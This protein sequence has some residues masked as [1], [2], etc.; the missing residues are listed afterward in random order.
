MVVESED[1]EP[2][3]P[4]GEGVGGLTKCIKFFFFYMLTGFI[5]NRELMDNLHFLPHYFHYLG[6]EGRTRYM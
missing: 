3:D 2:P 6:G 1:V 5:L 4:G